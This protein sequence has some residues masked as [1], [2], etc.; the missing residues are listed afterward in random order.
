MRRGDHRA[1]HFASIPAGRVEA[2]DERQQVERERRDPQQR[3]GRDVLRDVVGDGEQQHRP[4]RGERAPQNLPRE[5]RRRFMRAIARGGARRYAA[6]RDVRRVYIARAAPAGRDAEDDERRIATGPPERLPARRRPRL[7]QER[8]A[9]E[10]EHRRQ[11]RQREQPIRTRAGSRTREP[12]LYQRTRRRQQEVRQP[13]GDGQQ[14]EYQPRRILASLRLPVRGRHDRQNGER[15]HE[16]HRMKPPLRARRD[17]VHERVGIR[18][19][20]EQRGLEEHEARRPHRRG[21]AEPRKDL[22]RHHRLDEEQQERADEDRDGVQKHRVAAGCLASEARRDS[23]GA[24]SPRVSKRGNA[25]RARGVSTSSSAGSIRRDP[26]SAP[27]T[28]RCRRP[29]AGAA[30]YRIR[31]LRRSRACDRTPPASERRRGRR[32]G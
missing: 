14:S 8:I 12:R 1:E 3:H 19:A 22:L 25:K 11:V 7:E 6:R 20:G 26:S 10:R 16:Q 9:D 29:A 4:G 30:G 23:T 17:T 13:D 15:Q 21:S 31:P 32:R 5:G 2:Q 24:R 28:R 27:T 18:V